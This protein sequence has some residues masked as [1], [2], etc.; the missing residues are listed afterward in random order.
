MEKTLWSRGKQLFCGAEKEGYV[1][2]A[3]HVEKAARYRLRILAT[4][5]PD[6]GTIRTALDGKRL[7]PQFNLYSGRVSPA[8]SLELGD[9]H[10]T[11]GQHRLR[12]SS[13]GKNAASTG[14]YFGIDAIDLLSVVSEQ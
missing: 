11:V 10:F 13:S 8:G 1:E 3:M 14:Y 9:H 5:A 2:L 6:Y 12:F 4:A 7:P